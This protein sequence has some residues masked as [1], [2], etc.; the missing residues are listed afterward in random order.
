MELVNILH[1]VRLLGENGPFSAA[2]LSQEFGISPATVKRYI[3]TARQ[4]GADIVSVR[5]ASGFAFEIRNWSLCRP[6][7]ARWIQLETAR[8]LL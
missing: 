1:L 3:S 8:T 6:T 2:A 4:M 5:Y 7:V